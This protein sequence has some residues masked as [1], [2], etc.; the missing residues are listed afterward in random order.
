MSHPILAAYRKCRTA[1]PRFRHHL[2]RCVTKTMLNS[3]S[4]PIPRLINQKLFS[5][6]ESHCAGPPAMALERI[7]TLVWG[8][9][10][11]DRS[12][13]IKLDFTLLPY[14][15]LVWFL[16]GINR[17]SYATA[18]IS[19]MDKDL[20]FQGKDFN[21]MTT[22]YLVA[23]AVFQIPS[24]S[25]LTIFPPKYIFVT[26]NIV[27]SVL[28]LATFRMSHVY[29]VFVLNAFEGAFAAIC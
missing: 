1:A 23:Y 28:T 14:F 7:K 29:Q 25:L 26:S 16:F 9:P 18:Y 19:G 2:Q 10:S 5:I 15:S 3:Q 20:G 12:L 17:K 22:I 11:R 27:W 13:V 4:S 24:T 21:Y 8:P 6:R